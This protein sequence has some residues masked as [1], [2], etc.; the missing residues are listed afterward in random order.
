MRLK[1]KKTVSLAQRP[2]L[3][4]QLE[5]CSRHLGKGQR[6][7]HAGPARLIEVSPAGVFL[8][9]DIETGIELCLHRDEVIRFT[10]G[11]S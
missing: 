6:V 8:F 5:L 9:V 3:E 1:A 4:G 10:V 7:M 11:D 2:G